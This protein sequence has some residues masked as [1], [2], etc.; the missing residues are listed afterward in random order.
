M[1]VFKWSDIPV[2]I[3][4]YLSVVKINRVLCA[5]HFNG[6]EPCR[7]FQTWHYNSGTRWRADW[8]LVWVWFGVLHS[9]FLTHFISTHRERE[10]KSVWTLNLL[11]HSCL[12]WATTSGKTGLV[13]HYNTSLIYCLSLPWIMKDG[14][15]GPLRSRS[16]LCDLFGWPWLCGFPSCGLVKISGIK[17]IF[18]DISVKSVHIQKT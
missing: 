4:K 18:L 10:G 7:I 11:L 17:L 2:W 13:F 9:V 8:L 5:A 16:V 1:P 15:A 6:D 12:F 3:P 14:V